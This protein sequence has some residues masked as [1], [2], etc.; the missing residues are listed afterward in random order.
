MLHSKETKF[1]IGGGM[2]LSMI[3]LW[4]EYQ[5]GALGLTTALPSRGLIQSSI[6][7]YLF[8]SA[9]IVSVLFF[10]VF[11]SY[12]SMMAKY[13]NLK[14]SAVI[15]IVPL[16]VITFAGVAMGLRVAFEETAQI[17][18]FFTDFGSTAVSLFVIGLFFVS[19]IYAAIIVFA[20]TLIGSLTGLLFVRTTIEGY[21]HLRA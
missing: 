21:R 16:V 6:V 1:G 13:E 18:E 19:G 20:T 5:S 8:L 17:W 7:I 15:A 10:S 2:I 3:A 14:I 4:F 12:K 11:Q 9:F